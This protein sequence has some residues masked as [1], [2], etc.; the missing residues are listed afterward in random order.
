MLVIYILAALVFG[1]AA[2]LWFGKFFEKSKLK[3]S[4][5][6][7]ERILR[8]AKVKAEEITRK[9]DLDSKELLY[10]LRVEFEKQNS[11][12][13]EELSQLERRLTQAEKLMQERPSDGNA[14]LLARLQ[15][16]E[17]ELANR[18]AVRKTQP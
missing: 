4:K 17:V 2:G 18:K 6:D 9:A 3:K 15:R 16:A 14:E 5:E 13:R 7:A 1:L 12:K 10:K 8:D 11:S